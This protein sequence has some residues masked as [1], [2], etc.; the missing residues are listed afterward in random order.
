MRPRS[1]VGAGG[2]ERPAHAGGAGPSFATHLDLGSGKN[3]LVGDTRSQQTSSSSMNGG[4]GPGSGQ[5]ASGGTV[6]GTGTTTTTAP[7]STSTIPTTTVV[8]THPTGSTTTTTTLASPPPVAAPSEVQA[9]SACQTLGLEVTLT[10]TASPTM[11]VTSYVILRSTDRTSSY[12]SV[13]SVSG[14]TTVSFTD[15]TVNGFGST[16]WYEVKAV[17]GDSSATSSTVSATTPTMCL[18]G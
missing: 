1:D 3:S 18:S 6:G 2:S 14:R 13:G 10:W 15:A 7:G 16:Y 17:A 4:G 5:A 9:T 12:T 8:R 11:R